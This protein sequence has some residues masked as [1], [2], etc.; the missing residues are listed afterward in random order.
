[1]LEDDVDRVLEAHFSKKKATY[2]GVSPQGKSKLNVLTALGVAF[3]LV[4]VATIGT[5]A[6]FMIQRGSLSPTGGTDVLTISRTSSVGQEGSLFD[7]DM[8]PVL[9][10]EDCV[11]FSLPAD[12]TVDV[13]AVERDVSSTVILPVVDAEAVLSISV[14]C[15]GTLSTYDSY[16]RVLI[17]DENG[18]VHLVFGTDS[19]GLSA[20]A[21]SVSNIAEETMVCDEGCIPESVTIEVQD[22]NVHVDSLF[23][24]PTVRGE[25]SHLSPGP[26][27]VKGELSHLSTRQSVLENQQLIKAHRWNELIEDTGMVWYAA[28]TAFS[29]LSFEEKSQY[30]GARL[31]HLHGFE[32]YSGGYFCLD[33]PKHSEVSGSGGT[34]PTVTMVSDF[35][36]RSRHDANDP[37]SLYYD[38]DPLGSG[39]IPPRFTC[40]VCADC[41]AFAPVYSVEA[42]VN[43]YF[44]QHLDKD[45]SE[46]QVVSCVGDLNCSSGG[47]TS[48]A[49][50]YV[51]NTGIVPEDCFPYT[52]PCWPVVSQLCEDCTSSLLCSNP[53]D[54][55]APTDYFIQYTADEDV[56]KENLINYGPGPV[57]VAYWGH[58]MSLVGFGMVHVGDLIMD[59]DHSHTGQE[60]TVQPGSPFIGRTYWVFKQSWGDW[61]VGQTPYVSVVAEASHL[62]PRFFKTPIES[63]VY[64][65]ANIQCL[66]L[67]S[68]GYYNWGIGEKPDGY[69]TIPDEDDGNDNDP[70][71]GPLNKY[72]F[73]TVIGENIA[74]HQ[75][76]NPVLCNGEYVFEDSAYGS[77]SPVTFVISNPGSE[78]LHLTGSLPPTVLPLVG[79]TGE[80]YDDFEVVHYPSSTCIPPGGSVTFSLRFSPDSCGIKTAKVYIPNDDLYAH[81]YTFTVTGE[82]YPVYNYNTGIWYETIHEALDAAVDGDIVVVV[83][84]QYSTGSTV[85]IDKGVTLRSLHGAETTVIDGESSHRC[86][87]LDHDDAMLSGFT[88]VNGV[89]GYSY[90]GGVKIITGT[91]DRCIIRDNSASGGGGVASVE[92]GTITHCIIEENT[93][94]VFGGGILALDETVITNCLVRQNSAVQGGGIYAGPSGSFVIDVTTVTE[95]HVH[96]QVYAASGGGI[97]AAVNGIV[98]VTNSILV[99]NIND[100]VQEENNYYG[101][102]D[103]SYSCTSPLPSETGSVPSDA[104]NLDADPE[105]LLL[106]TPFSHPYSLKS[107]SPCIN[108]GTPGDILLPLLDLAYN[109]RLFDSRVDMGAYEFQR[110]VPPGGVSGEVPPGI[111]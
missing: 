27:N 54:I 62:T 109:P 56:I 28:V 66:D 70:H 26:G 5:W 11:F 47:H 90:G 36:W 60:I 35:D 94:Q 21:F 22:A 74:V 67:D 82:W 95:N 51:V 63:T 31:P 68:D 99:Y 58:A 73:E 100:A 38:G 9:Q 97:F 79:I 93:A 14:S 20:G 104:G 103:F 46:Q 12:C 69:P 1:M 40:Q 59:G 91:I 85:V 2:G 75:N 8:Q 105:F 107:S 6:G 98:S 39:W 41:W 18:Q 101:T 44:N 53:D 23:V 48:D 49:T 37:S 102:I 84:G 76:G 88:I 77:N 57:T 61:G 96:D 7:A 45:L 106:G 24:V 50:M 64:S 43:L 30:F 17:T 10:D 110:P 87:V 80:D 29:L 65:A 83:D 13:I 92:R 32:F 78:E 42:L 108:A 33:D 16:V 86:V 25:L 4:S 34:P 72:Y 19:F 111:T 55:I 81:P 71:I 89:A 3:L 15:S 52:A